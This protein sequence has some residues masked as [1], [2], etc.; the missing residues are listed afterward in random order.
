MYVVDEEHYHPFDERNVIFSRVLWDRTCPCYRH[1]V[2][3][4]IPA[5]VKEGNPGY[6][7][8]D[9]AFYTAAWTVYNTYEGAFSWEKL[10]GR[11]SPEVEA[12]PR[13]AGDPHEMAAIVK[14]VARFYGASLVGITPVDKRWVYTH[15]R[16]GNP[17][18][19]P[20]HLNAVVMGIAMD[21]RALGT[22]PALPA[23]AAVGIAY[24]KMAFLISCLGEFIRALGYYAIQMGNDTALSIPLAVDAGLGELGRNGLLITPDYG[25]RVRLCKVFTDVP[26]A[27][28]RPRDFGVQAACKTCKRCAEECEAG[29]ISS[30]EPTFHP[31][32]RSNNASV[33]KWPVN[34]E[35]CYQF[36][37]ENGGDCSTCITV[38]PFTRGV[39]KTAPEEFWEG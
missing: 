23:S 6:S 39:E 38:C 4:R 5:I 13:Y 11:G 20:D 29:A 1:A 18:L 33:L 12:L 7:H 8:V 26:L 27:H 15:D 25:S 30:G 35:K 21:P 19:I 32:C 14:Q 34:A 2:E 37:C 3:E 10:R 16:G 28:D 36:W 9:V 31:V 17:I 22:T 24:S